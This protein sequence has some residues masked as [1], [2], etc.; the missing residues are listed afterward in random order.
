[1][2]AHIYSMVGM[3]EDSIASNLSALE[4]QPDYYHAADFIVYAHLQLAQDSKAAAMIEKAS[5]TPERG[6]RPPTI[7]NHTAL[8]AMPA[9]YMIERGDWAGAAA[10][11]TRPTGFAPADSLTRFTRGLGM[12]RTGNAS[13][14]QAEI[15][16]MQALRA[17]MQTN[18][19]PYWIARTDEQILAISAWVAF[20]GGARDK[21]IALMR[22]A[23]D[24]ED[25]SLKHVA[26]EN[27]LYPMRELLADLLV[28]AGQARAAVTEYA[29]ALEQTPN[30]F[31]GIYGAA[32][33]AEA[34]GDR[35]NAIAYYT[36]LVELAKHA[37]AQRPELERARTYLS[38][39]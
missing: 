18:I 37:D 10:L 31:R 4:I 20:A 15:A 25:G 17:A 32:R 14:A 11:A 7:A 23:A 8:A 28:E 19:E 26:M 21:A 9:R 30:R 22:K 13:G 3:W 27:R 33:A 2:P 6:D 16:A 38:S 24:G 12:A 34:A 1:M 39:R 36:R 29:K 5:K 35:Q